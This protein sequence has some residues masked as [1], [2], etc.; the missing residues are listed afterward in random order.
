MGDRHTGSVPQTPH[1]APAAPHPRFAPRTFPRV[2]HPLSPDLL[3]HRRRLGRRLL[4]LE[5]AGSARWMCALRARLSRAGSD[6]PPSPRTPPTPTHTHTFPSPHRPR[7]PPRASPRPPRAPSPLPPAAH[8]LRRDGPVVRAAPRAGLLS[9]WINLPAEIVPSAVGV[10]VDKCTGLPPLPNHQCGDDPCLPV[11]TEEA[12]FA[13]D[14]LAALESLADLPSSTRV[15]Y[16][17]CGNGPP[18]GLVCDGSGI[19]LDSG[20]RPAETFEISKPPPPPPPCGAPPPAPPPPPPRPSPPPPPR[21]PSLPPPPPR[22][23]PSPRLPHLRLPPS[24]PPPLPPPPRAPP[25]SLPPPPGPG[26]YECEMTK[27]R[28]GQLRRVLR[29]DDGSRVLVGLRAFVQQVAKAAV[30]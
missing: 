24:L 1:P 26:F 10:C 18:P 17:D 15:S 11:F 12:I 25:L 6:P 3:D 22:P 20:C 21:R 16:A 13:S 28:H 27:T 9:T 19:V 2:W 14:K 29:I 8:A 4:H 23:P 30:A 7:S 5:A